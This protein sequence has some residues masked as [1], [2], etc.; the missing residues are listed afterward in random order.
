[1]GHDQSSEPGNTPIAGAIANLPS[2]DAP[3][4]TSH[5]NPTAPDPEPLAQQPGLAMAAEPAGLDLAALEINGQ[6]DGSGTTPEPASRAPRQRSRLRR[7]GRCLLRVMVTGFFASLALVGLY[8]F[9]PPPITPLMGIR[10]VTGEGLHK[11]WKD[12]EDISPNLARAV[13]ASEDARFC[14]HNGFDWTAMDKAWQRNQH[15]KRIRGGSTISNQT[16]KN[17]FLWPD[18]TYV[19]KAIEFYFTALIE[20]FWS[21]KRILEMYLNVVEWGPG[22]YGAEAAARLHFKKSAHDL[23]RHE[24]ALLA[25]VLPNPLHWSP[26]K[27]SA[28][29]R[30]RASTIEARMADVADPT[31]DPCKP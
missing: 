21:K 28:Y 6:P 1:M 14:L 22:T 19:R 12:Y 3:A 20:T 30:G 18:R 17:V 7:L 25:A 5:S 23:T 11:S 27:P 10:L 24:A 2:P 26:S 4:G 29:I 15:A 13:I 9:L 16:A 31:G 8:R